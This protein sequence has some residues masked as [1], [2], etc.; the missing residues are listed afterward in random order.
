LRLFM[1]LSRYLHMLGVF[2]DPTLCL[3]WISA[4]SGQA[5]FVR[6][7]LLYLRPAFLNMT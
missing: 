5:A 6:T 4:T 3:S 1:L 7:L 2:A